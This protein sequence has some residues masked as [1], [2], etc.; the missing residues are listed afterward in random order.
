MLKLIIVEK[1]E[2]GNITLSPERLEEMLK[3]TYEE[4][5]K[6]GKK[7]NI[8]IPVSPHKITTTPNLI[9]IMDC[10]EDTKIGTT[11]NANSTI[12]CPQDILK[13]YP[14]SYISNND[15]SLI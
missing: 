5:Y 8:S 7:E 11:S 6:I 4:A 12:V 13:N 2:N 1:D 14:I 9:P 3:E 10:E 15:D